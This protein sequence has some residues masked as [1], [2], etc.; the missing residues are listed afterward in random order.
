[1]V[2]RWAASHFCPSRCSSKPEKQ[3]DK[4]YQQ[5]IILAQIKVNEA[6]ETGKMNNTMKDEAKTK[7]Q[8]IAELKVL[9]QVNK[10]LDKH[11]HEQAQSFEKNQRTQT[12]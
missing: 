12:R 5:V 9:R 6:N 4:L 11:V 1:M 2:R 3:Y 7:K 10:D 8:L